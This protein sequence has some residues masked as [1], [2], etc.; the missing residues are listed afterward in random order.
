MKRNVFMLTACFVALVMMSCASTPSTTVARGSSADAA[1]LTGEWSATDVEEVSAALIS[2]AL[3]SPRIDSY[4]KEFAAKSGGDLPTVIVGRFRNASS[5][6]IDTSIISGKMRGAIINSGKLEFVEGGEM[7]EA[8][9]EER[10]DQQ[11]NASEDTAAALANETG[12]NFMLTGEVN[13]IVQKLGNQSSRTYYVKASITNLENNRI[14]WEGEADPI[15]K[16]IV[17]AKHKL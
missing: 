9:R 17:Q 1:D 16:Q 8:L 5:E 10:Q 7:R 4:L 13:S 11:A 6:R 12:A 15:V 2:Q 14:L 3:A